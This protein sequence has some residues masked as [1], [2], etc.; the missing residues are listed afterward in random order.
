M[1]HRDFCDDLT[2]FGLRELVQLDRV[3]E[4]VVFRDTFES[5]D[6]PVQFAARQCT[7][8]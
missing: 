4:T 2:L 7:R 5:S 8:W 3:D 1:E 6:F